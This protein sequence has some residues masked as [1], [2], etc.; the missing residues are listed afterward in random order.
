MTDADIEKEII[1]KELTAPRITMQD[2]EDSVKAID[3][4]VFEETNL[5]VCLLTLKNGF[6]VIGES[7]CVSPENFD[8]EIG[9]KIAMENAKSKI[10]ALLGFALAEK[11]ALKPCLSADFL[12]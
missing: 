11:L 9:E 1:Q 6:S 7:A 5:T 4:H 12:A 8:V 2:I 3:Y 10:W